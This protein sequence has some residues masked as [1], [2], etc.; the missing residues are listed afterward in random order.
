MSDGNNHGDARLDAG[1]S[2]IPRSVS[3][4]PTDWKTIDEKR[5]SSSRG[6][7]IAAALH[8]KWNSEHDGG[9]P[10]VAR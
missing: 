4:K 6:V 9:C 7:Y 5:G 3:M 2:V 1:R 10:P 8:K